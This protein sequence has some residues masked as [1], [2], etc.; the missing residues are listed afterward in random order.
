MTRASTAIAIVL[1]CACA[2][3]TAQEERAGGYWK[4]HVPPENK[5]FGNDDVVALAQGHHVKTD[6]SVP[7]I[8][9]DGNTYCF[10]DVAS[11]EMFLHAPVDY[12]RQATRHVEGGAAGPQSSRA[13]LPTHEARTGDVFARQT[14]ETS[15]C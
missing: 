15:R 2:A 3:A 14:Q 9:G 6:C 13:P 12:V 10:K 1:A 4:Y 11:R 5:P 7:W 8:G